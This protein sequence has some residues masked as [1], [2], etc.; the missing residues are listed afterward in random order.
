MKLLL[1]KR[2]PWMV[3]LTMIMACATAQEAS[4]AIETPFRKGVNLTG[5]FQASS[6][7]VVQYDKY[8]KQDF[9]N[10]KSLGFDH[11]RL[12]INL[13]YMTEGAN[14]DIMERKPGDETGGVNGDM[15]EGAPYYTL[16][17]T[18]LENLNRVIDWAEELQMHLIL[19]NH[20]FDPSMDTDPDVEDILHKVWA[21]MAREFADRSGYIYYEILNEPHGI[22]DRVWNRIQGRVIETIREYDNKHYIVVG[23][24]GW[25][26]YNNLAAMP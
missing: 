17:A 18:F 6:A 16:D 14:G 9:I 20:T 26:S 3:A 7:G 15:T 1:V 19:D 8:S 23:P 5:W 12:P 10:I 4:L 21:Q 13:H 2:A 24:A 22:K 25:N 11:I